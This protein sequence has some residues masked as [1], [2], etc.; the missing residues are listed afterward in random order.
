MPLSP[1]VSEIRTKIGHGMLLLPGV[2]AVIVGADGRLLL[3][4]HRDSGRWGLLGGG[5][6]PLER[7]RDAVVREVREELGVE[8]EVIGVLDGYGGPELETVYPNGDRVSYVT[9]AFLVRLLA[10]PHAAE[11]EEVTDVGWFRPEEIADLEL[12]KPAWMSQVLA[13]VAEHAA[14]AAG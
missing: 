13:D 12:G 7:P 14:T 6:E 9:T 8:S 5:V 4:R 10:A 3:A 2:T 11:V 1:Y